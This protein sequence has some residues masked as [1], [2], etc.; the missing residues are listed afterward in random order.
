MKRIGYITERR[1]QETAKG[2]AVCGP[3][4]DTGFMDSVIKHVPEI[5]PQGVF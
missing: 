4:I 5:K 2:R 3:I 1:L